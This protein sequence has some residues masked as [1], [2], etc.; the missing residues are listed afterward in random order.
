MIVY[1]H[2][3]LALA[4]LFLFSCSNINIDKQSELS[5]YCFLVAI[6]GQTTNDPDEES[7]LAQIFWLSG[8]LE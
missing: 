5:D 1:S 2:R 6:L 3:L 8:C 7:K 4:L